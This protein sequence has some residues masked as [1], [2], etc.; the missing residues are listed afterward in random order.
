MQQRRKE[1]SG[2]V[3]SNKMDKT[4]VVK[5]KRRTRHRLYGKTITLAKRYKA[6]DEENRCQ[7][8]DLVSIVESRPLSRDKRWVVKEILEP[9]VGK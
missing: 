5:V 8:G 4:V 7:M 6:H 3:V 1:L 2:Q 9:A